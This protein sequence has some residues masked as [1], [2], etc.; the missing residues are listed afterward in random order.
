MNIT[1]YLGSARGNDS[2][3]ADEVIRLG[4]WI[5][6][7]GHRLIYGGSRIG[8]MGELAEAVLQAGG[9]VIGIEPGFFVRSCLQH[10]GITKLI[11][12][13]TMAERKAKLIEHGDAYIAFPGGTGTLEEISE[14]MSQIRI[15]H[16]DSPCIIFNLDGYYEPLRQM[17][18]RMVGEGF[19]DPESRDKFLFAEDVGQIAE[20]LDQTT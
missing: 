15:G 11:V 18:D 13:E 17:L 19:L 20:I 14:V 6:R 12:T 1:V 9:E 4:N 16:N 7:N 5:G 10:D 2:K 3:Y 8:L